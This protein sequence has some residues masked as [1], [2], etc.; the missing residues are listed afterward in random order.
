M[1]KRTIAI[2]WTKENAKD[3][4]TKLL[5]SFDSKDNF[6][7][8]QLFM[9]DSLPQF[10][11]NEIK[12]NYETIV[13]PKEIDS[14]PKRKNFILGYAKS[15]GFDGFLHIVEDNIVL[16]RDPTQYIEKIEK[17]MDVLDYNVHFS[18]VTDPCNYIFKKFNPR[19]TLDVDDEDV[20]TRLGLPDKISFTSHS[21][22]C[23]TIFDLN[24]L[25]D[26]VPKFD[27]KFTIAMYVIIEYLARRRAQKKEGQ[28]YFMNQY[29]SISDEIGSFHQ[30]SLDGDSIDQQKMKEEDAMFKEMRVEFAPDN[31]LDVVLDTF[32]QKV[33]EKLA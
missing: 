3:N 20:K 19:L 26:D 11:D 33:K 18:T 15:K 8:V 22:I 14:I 21:N 30:I 5:D 27:E 7:R 28:L 25:G 29:L 23:W 24:K 4:V 6:C 10:K 2:E 13:F 31:N 1:N 9:L 17:T 12:G 16:D 32:Y